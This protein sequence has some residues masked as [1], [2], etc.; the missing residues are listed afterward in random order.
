MVVLRGRKFPF[1]DRILGFRVG[2]LNGEGLKVCGGDERL[3]SF[4]RAFFCLSDGGGGERCF[5]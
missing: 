3:W 2:G 1:C 5:V 4:V